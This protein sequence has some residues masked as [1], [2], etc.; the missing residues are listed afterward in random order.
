MY[1]PEPQSDFVSLESG[2]YVAV[3]YR[4]LDCGSHQEDW[5]GAPKLHLTPKI[6]LG[7][8]VPSVEIANKDGVVAPMV[9]NKRYTLSTGEQAHLRKDLE[10]WR[11]KRFEPADLGQNGRFKIEMLLGVAC[12]INVI[13]EPAK[14]GKIY[15][16]IVSIMPLPKGMEKPKLF[17]KPQ[18]LELTREKFDRELFEGLHE[19]LRNYIA[20]SAEYQALFSD[21][22]RSNGSAQQSQGRINLEEDARH[23]RLEAD[24]LRDANFVQQQMKREDLDDEI[25]F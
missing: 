16:N 20:E 18:H 19:G 24:R 8:E 2:T 11:G 3:C 14:N 6:T 10:A 13:R 17:N 22:N 25:P 7:W 9:I 12:M 23:R 21:R 4:V 15:S 5:Q 1:L